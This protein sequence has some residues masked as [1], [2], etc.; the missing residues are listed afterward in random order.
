MD[1]ATKTFAAINPRSRM[2]WKEKDEIKW[3]LL[4]ERDKECFL[5]GNEEAV[6]QTIDGLVARGRMRG[7]DFC[8]T[9]DFI[10]E[11]RSMAKMIDHK[12]RR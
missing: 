8:P 11:K 5:S 7:L 6:V 10:E 2:D 9:L 4:S 12:E 3:E 1:K